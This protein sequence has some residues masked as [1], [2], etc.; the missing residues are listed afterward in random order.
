MTNFFF[1]FS[2]WSN[3]HPL[4]YQLWR[5]RNFGRSS[6]V[7]PYFQDAIF[8]RF[9]LMTSILEIMR[10]NS[11]QNFL[12]YTGTFPV[13]R[14][15]RYI[16]HPVALKNTTCTMMFLFNVADAEWLSVD[17]SRK[18]TTDIICCKDT[19]SRRTNNSISSEDTTLKRS[20]CPHKAIMN[21]KHCYWFSWISSPPC[22]SALK[23]KGI[24][25]YLKGTKMFASLFAATSHTTFS[26]VLL[27]TPDKTFVRQYTYER[28]WFDIFEDLSSVPST[29]AKGFLVHTEPV[30]KDLATSG[31]IF[32]CRSEEVVSSLYVLDGRKNCLDMHS[33]LSSSDETC[34]AGLE[35]CPLKCESHNCK[36]SPLHF[37]TSNGYCVS[38]NTS[39]QDNDTEQVKYFE[40]SQ[41]LRMDY[42]LVNDLISDCD[43]SGKDE[44]LFRENLQK[45]T[46]F[47]CEKPGEIPCTLGH[48]KCYNISDICIYKLGKFN[49]LIPCRTGSP[50]ERCREFECSTQFKCP[51]YYC[52][53]W[54]LVCNSQWDCPF[55]DDE[56]KTN[57]CGTFRNCATMFKCKES[58]MCLH[59]E[60][61]CDGMFDCPSKDDELMCVLHSYQCPITCSCLNF[62]ISCVGLTISLQFV[63]HA[64][65]QSCHIVS[66]NIKSCVV[67]SENTQLINLNL[68]SNS[69]VNVCFKFNSHPKIQTVDYSANF[70]ERLQKYCFRNIS[71]LKYIILKNNSLTFIEEGAFHNL[72]EIKLIDFSLNY[73]QAL[74]QCLFVTVPHINILNMS[75]NPLQYADRNTFE[76]TFT[77][78]IVTSFPP[79][80]CIKPPGATCIVQPVSGL[81]NISCSKLFPAFPMKIAFS[82]I[83][84]LMY[85]LNSISLI[86]HR[87]K[88][89]DNRKL[90]RMNKGNPG[91]GLYE[92]IVTVVSVANI[93]LG[94][95]LFILW[96]ADLHFNDDFVLNEFLWKSSDLC[97]IAFFLTFLFTFMLPLSLFILALARLLTTIYPMSSKF[98][99][100]SFVQRCVVFYVAVLSSVSLL[101]VVYVKVR[102][103]VLSKMCS[104]FVQHSSFVLEANILTLFATITHSVVSVSVVAMYTMLLVSL[105]RHQGTVQT[106]NF[107]EV[108]KQVITR[109]VMLN[110]PNILCWLSSS[111][112]YVFFLFLTDKNYA[113]LLWSTATIMPATCIFNPIYFFGNTKITRQRRIP[114]GHDKKQRGK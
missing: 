35:Y 3:V 31:N 34:V 59:I 91:S 72:T 76:Q 94:L 50:L 66:C 23:R 64:P 6:L 1:F 40:C 51:D 111:G 87:R 47:P 19:K 73:L 55:G 69:I 45:S 103:K 113:I 106:R 8:D 41:K 42:R 84:S 22:G 96:A 13:N 44:P 78:E 5:N 15:A 105:K 37:Q 85:I 39:K 16:L 9:D 7:K 26:V 99:S 68:S 70:V 101:A 17:C 83:F 61:V 2:R 98:K 43:E 63:Q 97:S 104:P 27:D 52:I 28:M 109:S 79:L 75:F 38:Y 100:R 49:N 88:D 108:N 81:Y 67:F 82:F 86:V 56:D 107:Q 89:V 4:A 25:S 29:E 114:C 93:L 14:E 90:E 58:P 102:G 46:Y 57:T 36:C 65:F 33:K 112:V 18:I 24:N 30:T 60:S 71:L 20:F 77:T 74:P 10:S 80:C 12:F 11:L 21:Q 95:Y 48:P 54:S 110:L 32:Q 53:P 62:A 92:I